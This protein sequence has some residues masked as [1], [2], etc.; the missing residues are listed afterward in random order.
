MSID[1]RIMRCLRTLSRMRGQRGGGRV[2]VR[3]DGL[4]QLE[5]VFLARKLRDW[6]R[7]ER[8]I[9]ELCVPVDECSLERRGNQMEVTR[10]SEPGQRREGLEDVQGLAQRHPA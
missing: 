1:N 4:V 5:R 10:G 8:R 6:D 9:P 2:P 3:R 7:C